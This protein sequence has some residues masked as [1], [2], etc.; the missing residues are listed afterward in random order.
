MHRKVLD[1]IRRY[2]MIRRDDRVFVALSGGADS[3]ALLHVLLRLRKQLGFTLHALHLNHRLRGAESLRD[4]RFVR[5]LCAERGVPLT[6]GAANVADI[7]KRRGLSVE[8]C[9]RQARYAFFA[10][11]AAGPGAKVATAHT[12]ADNA[13]TILL[14][15]LRGTGLRGLCGIPP[16]RGNIIRPLIGC[17]AAD[18]ADYC[19]RN[20]LAFVTDSSN[21]TD[22][23]TRNRLRRHV[24]PLLRAEN[25]RVE[26]RLCLMSD[27]LRQDADYL[28]ARAA[29]AHKA[30]VQPDGTFSRRAF[31]ALDAALR[32]RVLR[33]MLRAEGLRYDYTRLALMRDALES[34]R[35]GVRL[36]KARALRVTGDACFIGR[37]GPKAHRLEPASARTVRVAP[38][39]PGETLEIT[40]IPEKKVYF[41]TLAAINYEESDNNTKK[42]LKNILDYDKIEKIAVLRYARP[43][44]RLRPAGRGCTKTLKNLWREAGVA[45]P[46]R[47]TELLLESGGQVLWTA[48]FGPDERAAPGA[49]TA[50][51][52]K[53]EVAEG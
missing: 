14:N 2:G 28:D 19:A 23:Y 40:G 46:E 47:R 25:P 6:V 5:R 53:I 43:A 22:A 4:E 36:S 49:Q 31:L 8:V 16:V 21:L 20:R 44:D 45:P 30:L 10:R 24:L 29:S 48:R 1:T 9:A 34:G 17:T 13:E 50:W 51:I 35:G 52:L 39:P 41:E 15:L 3:A 37:P 27:A 7:A 42:H 18:V 26:E 11:H 38:P 32:P 33:N 12:A